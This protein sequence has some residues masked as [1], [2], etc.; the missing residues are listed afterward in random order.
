MSVLKPRNRLVFFRVSEDE[1]Q[2]LSSMCTAG[3]GARSISEL[4]RSAVHRLIAE[5]PKEEEVVLYKLQNLDSKVTDLHQ[6][7]QKLEQTF[8]AAALRN[9]SGEPGK[10]D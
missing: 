7:V 5:N 1:F 3:D 9:D 8:S 6:L 10:R 2:K 4:A